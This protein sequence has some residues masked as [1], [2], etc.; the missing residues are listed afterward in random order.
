MTK[1]T[2]KENKHQ[3]KQPHGACCRTNPTKSL[4]F[5]YLQ[6]FNLSVNLQTARVKSLYLFSMY[7]SGNRS[8]IFEKE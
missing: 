4:L 3:L 6:Q 2:L 8:I 5:L 1:L 7:N